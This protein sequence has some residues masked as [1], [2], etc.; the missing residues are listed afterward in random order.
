VESSEQLEMHETREGTDE[1]H[2]RF[3]EIAEEDARKRSE[4]AE[5]LKRDF[6][7]ERDGA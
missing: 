7:A 6:L 3:R 1:E 4:A 5:K 2:V